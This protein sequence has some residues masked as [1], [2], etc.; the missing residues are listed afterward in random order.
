M[1]MWLCMKRAITASE[2]VKRAYDDGRL[3]VA[4]ASK[5][6]QDHANLIKYK[7]AIEQ[8]VK[9]ADDKLSEMKGTLEA[10]K[11]AEEAKEAVTVM[12]EETE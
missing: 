10:A 7:E 2:R 8:Q 1:D 9:V 3:K 4:E 12:L 6:L 11:E 5:V